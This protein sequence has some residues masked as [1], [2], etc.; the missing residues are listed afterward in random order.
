[1]QLADRPG[2]L[3]GL[4]PELLALRERTGRPHFIVLDEAHH[5][6]PASWD[7]GATALPSGLKGFLFVT[8][9]PEAL[10]ARTLDCVD[11]ALAVGTEATAALAVF[12][13]AQG[14]PE[15]R[16]THDLERGEVLTIC[17]TDPLP[18]RFKIIP[19]T[20]ERQ[21]HVRKYAEGKLGDDKAFFFR[22]PQGKLRLRATNLIMFLE[23]ADGVDD[24]TW[25]WHR[26][27]GD[28]SAWIEASI[29]DH[30]LSAELR[31]IEQQAGAADETRRQVRVAIENRY[32]L[33]G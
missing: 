15:P 10:S 23:M 22:G 19:G 6:L 11:R 26:A 17:R 20:T 31:A 2:Y 3:A 32:T 30:D 14:L 4:L 29:K 5:M 24:E 25:D 27:R 16:V 1:M 13:R 8:T 33:P 12:A 7:P 9:R 21:R 28:F 18:R